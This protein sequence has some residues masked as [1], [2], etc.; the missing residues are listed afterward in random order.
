M[1]YPPAYARDSSFID[2]RVTYTKTGF[3]RSAG[4]PNSTIRDAT[5]EGVPLPIFKIG[6]RVYVRGVDAIAYLDRLGELTARQNAQ[7]R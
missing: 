5:R 2:P 4:L 6:R 1:A 3:I 7:P